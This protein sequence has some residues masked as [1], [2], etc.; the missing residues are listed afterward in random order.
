ME[1]YIKEFFEEINNQIK[2][3]SWREIAKALKILQAAYENDG[4][5]FLIGNGGSAAISSHFA[6]DLN[7]TVFGYRGDK[8][9]KRFQ[10]ISLADNTSALT[11][12]SNDVGFESVFAEQLKN[13]AQEK[14][15]LF[16][17]SSSGNSP[18]IIKAAEV[19]KNLNMAVIGLAGFDGGKLLSLADAKIHVP[20]SKYQIVESAHDDICHLITTYFEEIIK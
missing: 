13:F 14:D 1:N 5:I 16:A 3:V 6:N 17:I 18:N 19:A 20:S 2:K 9:A 4:K 11:A 7:K 15:I 8:K 10:A 12:W